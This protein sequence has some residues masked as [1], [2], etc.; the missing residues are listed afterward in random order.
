MKKV[1]L[2]DGNASLKKVLLMMKYDTSK[3]LTENKVIVETIQE[4]SVTAM[5]KGF[6]AGAA[7][8]AAIGL[9]G[10]GVGAIPGALVGGV[11]GSVIAAFGNPKMD[12]IKKMFDACKTGKST[13]TLSAAELDVISDQINTAIDGLGTDEESISDAFKQLPTIPDLCGLIKAYETHGDLFSDLE[14]DLDSDYEWKQYV[15]LPLRAAKRKS[16]EITSQAADVTTTGSAYEMI[17]AVEPQATKQTLNGIEGAKIIY[18]NSFSVYII[19]PKTNAKRFFGYNLNGKSPVRNGNWKIENGKLITFGTVKPNRPQFVEGPTKEEVKSGEKLLK[20]G[21]KGAF[22]EELQGILNTLASEQGN[23]NFAVGKVDGKFGDKTKKGLQNYQISAGLE[24][25]DGVLGKD[26]YASLFR[27]KDKLISTVTGDVKPGT[28]TQN[29]STIADRGVTIPRVS[30]PTSGV[31]RAATLPAQNAHV[32]PQPVIRES[33]KKNL[34]TKL[35]EKTQE[36]ENLII[37]SKI[38]TNRFKLI[39]EGLV[40]ETDNDKIRFV[41]TVIQETNYL[42]SQG[43]TS[44]SINEGLFSA[45]G[46]LFGGSL[47]SI[48]AV[49]G[50]YIAKWLTRTL[51][52]PQ[53][54]FIEA[55]IMALVGNLNIAD[56]DKFFTDCRFASNKIA[57][58]LIEGYLIQMQNKMSATS[59][60][61]SGFIVSALR[62]AVAENFL[63]DKEGIIQ[64]LQDKIGDFICPKL[65]KVSSVIADKTEEIKDKAVA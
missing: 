3:T 46:G 27:E 18:P 11:L 41:E 30:A 13:P 35:V 1:N 59:Q 50:E 36:R 29:S 65:A 48:P 28:D 52:V 47:K 12:E 49:F 7:S 5:R 23:T 14:G 51:G 16:E 21:M 55:A 24:P 60:G 4:Q 45:L 39:S 19:D 44:K 33:L 9:A 26:T 8:G 57:D 32:D 6:V 62:N 31:Q 42:V 38:I 20:S 54:S 10:A 63:E 17:K 40:I 43:Y 37:E 58:S 2:E 56:Y 64:I 34:K 22:V 53:G 25:A 61:A 15:V